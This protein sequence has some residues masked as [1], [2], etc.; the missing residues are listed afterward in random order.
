MFH[1]QT[2]DKKKQIQS[3]AAHARTV[4]K[5]IESELNRRKKI[6]EL[7]ENIEKN[8]PV[9]KQKQRPLKKG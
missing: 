1:N 3:G 6:A 5:S 2:D 4:L 8:S 9:N 7:I